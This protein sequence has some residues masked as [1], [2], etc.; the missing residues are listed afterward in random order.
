MI[1]NDKF[2]RNIFQKPFSEM[3]NFGNILQ[4]NGY[5]ESRNKPNLFYKKFDEG[6]FFAD[7][8][9]TEEVPIWEDT[10][11]LF[12]WKFELNAPHW[13]ARRLIRKELINLHNRMCYCRLSFDWSMHISENHLFESVKGVYID[14]EN[15][16]FDWGDGYCR[17]CKKDFQNDGEF[18]SKECE[19]IYYDSMKTPCKVCGQK[20]ELFEEVSHH[21]S[22]F[23]EKTIYVHRSCHNLIHKSNKYPHLKPSKE[24]INKY[25][26]KNIS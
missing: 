11:P 24:D 21:T 4:N 15:A 16:I 26:R 20:I 25:Y 1:A 8:R 5:L 14:E 23:P 9:G 22:Y 7:M 2:G 18:C 6:L 19:E 17:V 13:K 12:Y 3:L 10:R